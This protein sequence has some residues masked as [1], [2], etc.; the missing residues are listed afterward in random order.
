M[1][2]GVALYYVA[3]GEL[4]SPTTLF[5][6]GFLIAAL[7]WAG[8]AWHLTKKEGAPLGEAQIRGAKVAV[9]MVLATAGVAFLTKP[10]ASLSWTVLKDTAHLDAELAKAREAGKPAVVDIWATW[11]VYC[12]K[13]ESL[14]G[15][16]KELRDRFD[17]LVR[18]KIDVT[19]DDRDD[20][21]TA[22]CMGKGQPRL[23]FFDTKTRILLDAGVD[24]WHGDD[25]KKRL[26]ESLDLVFGKTP[27]RA[28]R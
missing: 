2:V 12:K 7:A 19:S 17:Q 8:V 22:I 23:V 13:Y 28:S 20:L 5:V 21:R 14:I 10:G 24:N 4:I 18:L 25:S 26:M 15:S 6:A 16:D 3:N 1:L 27:D 11:C 9:L